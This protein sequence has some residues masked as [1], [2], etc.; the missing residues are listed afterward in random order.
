[1]GR[2]PS[3]AAGTLTYRRCAP[4]M[5]SISISRSE[6][7]MAAAALTPRIRLMAICDRVRESRTEAGV[8]DLRGLR[9]EI[10]AKGFPFVPLQLW[11]FLLLSS[12]RPGIFSCYVRVVNE[13]T[14]KAIFFRQ[15]TPTPAFGINDKML[16]RRTRIRC[17][18]PEKGRYTVQVWFFQEQG[19][20]VL[21]GEMPC[22]VVSEGA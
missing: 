9:Q 15:L 7:P 19:S 1:M 4:I 2:S 11:L 10:A 21:K 6:K 18:F 13:R 17:S 14:D 16:A 8:Y 5:R 20:D 3:G 22:S 12:P